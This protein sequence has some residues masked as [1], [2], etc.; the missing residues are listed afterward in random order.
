MST[1]NRK[2]FIKTLL[3]SCTDDELSVLS[4]LL[5]GSG[6]QTIIKRSANPVA[7]SNAPHISATDKGVKLCNLTINYT[8]WLGYLI[9]TDDYCVL[10][11]F[12]DAQVLKMF[13]LTADK[14][15]PNTVDEELNILELRSTLYEVSGG[16]GSSGGG[17]GGSGAS[18]TDVVLDLSNLTGSVNSWQDSG[19]FGDEGV[20]IYTPLL[21]LFEIDNGEVK[22]KNS[23]PPT[24]TFILK[25]S[26]EYVDPSSNVFEQIN[27]KLDMSYIYAEEEVDDNV[28]QKFVGIMCR[29]S[30]TGIRGFEANI[31]IA[32]GENP[33][34]HQPVIYSWSLQIGNFE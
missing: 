30:D 7:S 2:P 13:D 10:I 6:D 17:S 27:M 21:N 31:M 8:S 29:K 9:Y 3:E 23:I 33:E 5:D 20:E 25:N 24:I 16:S 32:V 4:S 12:T 1:I 34:T 19:N 26:P 15:I 28:Y 11:S 14:T 18:S 22:P